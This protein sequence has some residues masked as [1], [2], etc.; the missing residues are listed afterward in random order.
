MRSDAVQSEPR[1]SIGLKAATAGALIFLHFPILLIFLYAFNVEDAAYTFP[2]PGL[3]TK[4]FGELFA[5]Q[6]FWNALGLSVVVAIVAPVLRKL[7]MPA[8]Y[9]VAGFVIVVLVVGTAIRSN[10]FAG[11]LELWT[12]TASKNPNSAMVRNNLGN[13]QFASVAEIPAEQIDERDARL[14]LAK[15]NFEAAVHI[16]PTHDG[17]WRMLGETLLVQKKPAD[18]VGMF[19][20]TLALEAQ[21]QLEATQRKTE[22]KLPAKENSVDAAMGRGRALAELQKPVAAD[23]ALH[24]AVVIA[25]EIKRVLVCYHVCVSAAIH[26][27]VLAKQPRVGR[28]DFLRLD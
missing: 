4:W 10:V 26:T 11:G 15:Q 3:T 17:A 27:Q 23:D 24:V 5:R 6:A 7:P 14:A 22:Q 18:A 20:K 12:D 16:D 2:P 9:T 13:S 21:R 19:D 28:G 8:A 25:C 1:A